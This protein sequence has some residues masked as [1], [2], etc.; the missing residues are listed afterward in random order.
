MKKRYVNSRIFKLIALI[1]SVVFFCLGLYYPI[2][3]TKKQVLGV[4]LESNSIR[5]T[6]SIKMFYQEGSYLLGSIILIF[7][8]VFPII[9]YFNIFNKIFSI[10]DASNKA[11]YIISKL[12]KWSMLDVFMIALLLLNFKMDSNIIVMNLKI[13]TSYIALAVIFRMMIDIDNSE[14]IEKIL[15]K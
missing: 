12:D 3:S 2:L 9:K 4:V 8:L 14:K 7:T 13:G 10:F 15:F 5:L 11:N 6:D 1:L